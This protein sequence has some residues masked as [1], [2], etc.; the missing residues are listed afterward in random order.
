VKL[1]L[2][3]RR[4]HRSAS[5]WELMRIFGPKRKEATGGRDNIIRGR[6]I[7]KNISGGLL[8]ATKTF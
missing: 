1:G 4:E 8:E 2:A 7:S 5:N 3:L 6:G